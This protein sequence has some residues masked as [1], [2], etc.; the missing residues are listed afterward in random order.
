VL[1]ADSGRVE[2]AGQDVT[3]HSAAQRCHAGMARTYQTPRPFS[4]MPV[5][6]NVLVGAVHGAG[7]HGGD[8][9][10]AAV[11]SLTRTGLLGRAN[12]LAGDL[13]LLD[14]KRLELARA[15]ACRPR[16]LLLDEIAGGL[17]DAELPELIGI[18]REVRAAGTAVVWIEHIVHAL[19]EV[20]DRMLCLAS[21]SVLAVGTP[22]EVLADAQVREVYLGSSVEGLGRG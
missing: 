17:T 18:V 4:G 6:E 5:F 2:L 10:D 1:A 16:L 12:E 15:L 19:V 14:R 20:V 13:R 3:R 22:A 7:R 21:G 8:A 9:H 11:G